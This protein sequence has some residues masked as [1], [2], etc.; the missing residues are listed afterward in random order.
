MAW[1]GI[2]EG[3]QSSRAALLA[4]PAGFVRVVRFFFA[5]RFH[6]QPETCLFERLRVVLRILLYSFSVP[7]L[8]FVTR[9]F[10]SFFFFFDRFVGAEAPLLALF[11]LMA[12]MLWSAPLS[13]SSGRASETRGLD[14]REDG[15]VGLDKRRWYWGWSGV[16]AR[17]VPCPP[18]VVLQRPVS[19]PQP[20]RA[21]TPSP[22]SFPPPHP[23]GRRKDAGVHIASRARHSCLRGLV[24]QEALIWWRAAPARTRRRKG[25]EFGCAVVRSR[26]TT[27]SHAT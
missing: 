19:S 2:G 20:S 10:L 1:S 13:A 17:P 8:C 15:W 27:V 7:I 22:L 4:A 21:A 11:A 5:G 16:D 6:E 12:M 3:R 18:R 25:T 23:L 9:L 26:T 24:H 14:I